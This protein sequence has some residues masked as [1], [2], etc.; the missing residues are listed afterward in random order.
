MERSR[1]V[2]MGGGMVAGYAAKQLVESGMKKGELTILTADSLPPYERP[3]LSKSFLAG[4][5]TNESILINPESFYRDHGIDLRLGC[6]VTSIDPA[7]KQVSLAS[8]GRLAY[9]K[10][11]VATGCRPKV[12]NVPGHDL[13]RVLYLRSAGDSQAIRERMAQ[14]KRAVVIGGGF[15]GMEVAS[16]LAQQGNEPVMVFPAD[17]VWK[18]FFTP[19][20]SRFFEAYFAARGVQ[21]V[22][23]ASVARIL[24][25]GAVRGVALEGGRVLDCDFVVPGIGASPSLDALAGSGISLDDGVVVNEF[26]ETDQRD[27]LA[28][29]DIANYPDLVFGTRRRVE[30]WDNAVAQGQYCARQLTG[31][32]APFRHVPYF[33]SD[34]FDLSYEFWGDPEG[35][36]SVISRGDLSTN[37]FSVWWLKAGVLNASFVMNRPAEERDY[38]AKWIEARQRVSAAKLADEKTPIGEAAE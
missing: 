18:Q 31:E 27:I 26:L 28:A 36:G 2:L 29:G 4:R 12:L 7:Q 16:V 35:A 24:G 14:S 1:F 9:E 10:L 22:K 33:F 37:Q 13:D 19:E 23:Q 38:A 34:V 17:R 20:M 15:I 11:V 30:H 25:D 8:G 21:M 3:P 5:D 6:H 32:R